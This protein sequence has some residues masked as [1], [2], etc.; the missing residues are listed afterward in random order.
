MTG[1]E[2]IENAK[3]S[4]KNVTHNYANG[5]AYIFVKEPDG[6]ISILQREQSGEYT[7]KIQAADEARAK[8]YISM[9]EPLPIQLNEI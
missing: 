6:W 8:G 7:P 3:K 9:I 5:L 1:K 4:G 2:Y